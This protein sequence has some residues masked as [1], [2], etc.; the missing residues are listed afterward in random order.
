MF[1]KIRTKMGAVVT[2]ALAALNH[3]GER[4]P[5]P[6]ASYAFE[7]RSADGALK[8]SEDITNLVTTA[9]KTDLLDKYFRGSG[10]TAA[11]FVGLIDAAGFTAVAT[12]DTMASHGGWTEAVPY[13]SGTRPALTLS[14]ATS[15]SIDNSA[16]KAAFTINATALL[17]GAFL[18]TDSTKSGSTGTLYSAGVFAADRAVQS[19][20]VLS[21]QVTLQ[22]S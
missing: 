17:K 15:G 7:C 21:V 16:S 12:A 11:W 3:Y 2:A 5:A 18:N 20:D 1:D 14:A 10:Y 4:E 9:G 13:A 8:W 19:G 22:A 6:C